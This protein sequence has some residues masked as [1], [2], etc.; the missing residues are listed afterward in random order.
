M[1]LKHNTN[2]HFT[3]GLGVLK[4]DQWP[5]MDSL[6]GRLN[7]AAAPSKSLMRQ[8]QMFSD[9]LL[10]ICLDITVTGKHRKN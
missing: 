2:V 4:S 1:F 5:S 9:I 8:S 10:L 7:R 6:V 3:K